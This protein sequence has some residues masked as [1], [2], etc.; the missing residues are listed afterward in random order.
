MSTKCIR[1][2]H[3]LAFAAVL[4]AVKPV[5]ATYYC[6][7]QNQKPIWCPMTK[8]KIIALGVVLGTIAMVLLL[9]GIW[10]MII[11]CQLRRASS[12]SLQ[13]VHIQPPRTPARATDIA[14]QEYEPKQ[15]GSGGLRESTVP[16]ALH[17]HRPTLGPASDVERC[18]H[19][20][21]ARTSVFT[22]GPVSPMSSTASLL[23]LFRRLPCRSYRTPTIVVPRARFRF[24]SII[25]THAA[26]RLR[27][28]YR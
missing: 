11:H 25:A 27:Q 22:E 10:A 7:N 21:P 9:F 19:D 14:S 4:L 15:G 13:R 18:A 16:F 23:P 26:R 1:S 8:G 6:Y 20:T 5:D 3:Y 17:L 2:S 12:R 28:K 24:T